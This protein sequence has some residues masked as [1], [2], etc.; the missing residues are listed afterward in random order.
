MSDRQLPR[1]RPLRRSAPL[2]AGLVLLILCFGPRASVD[3]QSFEYPNFTGATGLTLLGNAQIVGN[4]LRLTPALNSQTGVAWTAQPVA[5]AGGFSTTFQFTITPLSGGADGMTFAIQSSSPTAMGS[6]AAGGGGLGYHG[7][8]NSIVVE[9]DHYPN[10]NYN[11]PN[12]NHISIHTLNGSPNSADENVASLGSTSTIA[13]LLGLHTATIEYAEGELS[14]AIDGTE[15]LAV[16]VDLSLVL[17]GPD[18]YVGFTGATGGLNEQHAIL[19]WSFTAG[20]SISRG[21]ADGDGR[22]DL[23][24]ALAV[25]SIYHVDIHTV[26]C[27]DAGDADDDGLLTIIDAFRIL[28]DLYD[29]FSGVPPIAPPRGVCGVDTTPDVLDCT[30]NSCP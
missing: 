10:G 23:S 15:V 30:V 20:E 12:G 8:P 21:D 17:G 4:T 9:F 13:A 22:I 26:P 28:A 25:L 16:M 19:S 29:G 11:D 7:I 1:R 14:V 24:D 3:G 5:V 27:A 6:A 18:A 2:T